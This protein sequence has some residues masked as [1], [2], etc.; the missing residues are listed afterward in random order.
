MQM[1]KIRDKLVVE[2]NMGILIS[3]FREEDSINRDIDIKL[4]FVDFLTESTADE[5][6]YGV[7]YLKEKETTLYTL[8]YP[9]YLD[10][11]MYG[12]EHFVDIENFEEEEVITL[13]LKDKLEIWFNRLWCKLFKRR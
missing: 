4:R 13:S 9:L 12:I 1:L 2:H 6:S 8:I 11:K 7:D 3:A 10:F 5:V